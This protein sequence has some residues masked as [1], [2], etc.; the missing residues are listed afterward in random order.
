[1]RQPPYQ[2]PTSWIAMFYYRVEHD[3]IAELGQARNIRVQT[4][5]NTRTGP[6]KTNYSTDIGDD[7]RLREFA[8]R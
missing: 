1:M 3:V 4:T 6:L 2:I 5:E 7:P 8:S